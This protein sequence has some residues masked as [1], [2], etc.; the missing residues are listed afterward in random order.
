ML[1]RE[2]YSGRRDHTITRNGI[3]SGT[4]TSTSQVEGVKKEY[5]DYDSMP[6]SHATR[7][8]PI[9]SSSDIYTHASRNH[10]QHRP[11]DGLFTDQ[12]TS[13]S[14]YSALRSIKSQNRVQ[15]E[16][17][18]PYDFKLQKH[19]QKNGIAHKPLSNHRRQHDFEDQDRNSRPRSKETFGADDPNQL[20]SSKRRERRERG[21][22][23]SSK[24]HSSQASQGIDYRNKSLQRSIG[25]GEP[26]TIRDIIDNREIR[27]EIDE[28]RLSTGS[29]RAYP[30]PS[31]PSRKHGAVQKQS[32][33]GQRESGARKPSKSH[34]DGDSTRDFSIDQSMLEKNFRSKLDAVIDVQQLSL[35]TRQTRSP[36]SQDQERRDRADSYPYP[37]PRS[38]ATQRRQRDLYHSSYSPSDFSQ[39]GENDDDDEERTV[40]LKP[41]QLG[42]ISS[43]PVQIQAPLL[44]Q[45]DPVPPSKSKRSKKRPKDTNAAPA[46]RPEDVGYDSAEGISFEREVAIAKAKRELG[47]S[48]NG[49]GP[50]SAPTR[51][52]PDRPMSS[53][54]DHGRSLELGDL[55]SPTSYKFGGQGGGHNNLITRPAPPPSTGLP[56]P[57][58]APLPLNITGGLT[59]VDT[60]RFMELAGTLGEGQAVGSVLGTLKGMIRDLKAERKKSNATIKLL[61]K[62]LKKTNRELN[63]AN[64]SKERLSK[65]LS[66]STSSRKSNGDNR[67][68]GSGSILEDSEQERIHAGIQRERDQVEKN[69]VMLQQ[70]IAAQEQQMAEMHARDKV[71]IQQEEH[72]MEL[73]D[74]ESEEETEE[75]SEDEDEDDEDKMPDHGDFRDDHN[76]D[77]GPAD[78]KIEPTKQRKGSKDDGA[79][80]LK[81]SRTGKRPS[82][83]ARTTAKRDKTRQAPLDS[84]RMDKVEEVHIHHHVHYSDEEDEDYYEIR[85]RH[86]EQYSTMRSNTRYN[87]PDDHRSHVV[88]RQS[89]RAPLGTIQIP[90]RDIM[91]QSYPGQRS[92]YP[93][94]DDDDQHYQAPPHRFRRSQGHSVTR[95]FAGNNRARAF[96]EEERL[97]REVGARR[98]EAAQQT[99]T[100]TSAIVVRSTATTLHDM[101]DESVSKIESEVESFLSSLETNILDETRDVYLDKERE[102]RIK[103]HE[104][105]KEEEEEDNDDDDDYNEEVIRPSKPY[106]TKGK[107]KKT[108]KEKRHLQEQPQSYDTPSK[109]H[110]GGDDTDNDDHPEQRLHEALQLL[111]EE[112]RELRASYLDLTEDLEVLTLEA[113]LLRKRQQIPEAKRSTSSASSQAV[114]DNDLESLNRKKQQIREQLRKVIDCLEEKADLVMVLQE[115]ALQEQHKQQDSRELQN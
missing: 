10:P 7:E 98:A 15:P 44:I 12:I 56:L 28:L 83:S 22:L 114:V 96:E 34:R 55:V 87:Y 91:S 75:E 19:L 20:D 68:L 109:P 66:K 1:S 2:T 26:L 94:Y 105:D 60:Q 65:A 53:K 42:I 106:D 21:E 85:P 77:G 112:V 81:S 95:G 102:S 48:I 38:P 107:E 84:R 8:Q 54:L 82:K 67:R 72:L 61:Q 52:Q 59:R 73:I 24:L 58:A 78:E 6:S 4:S 97:Q 88:P 101:M 35:D 93:L 43:T 16:E 71:R 111:E 110:G 31:S 92:R 108:N 46:T 104:Q 9:P 79:G 32:G 3:T 50:S 103:E 51:Q 62:D 40:E 113:E 14:S 18:D 29:N 5:E 100:A 17:M 37:Y 23:F 25:S 115:Q 57:S 64:E 30:S 70:R 13:S 99:E 76:R 69:L 74:T 80:V 86:T 90:V 11:T 39:T 47:A 49:P 63:K 89:Y 36:V 45:T 33:A 41:G 27:N